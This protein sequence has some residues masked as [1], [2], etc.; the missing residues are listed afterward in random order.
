DV[1]RSARWHDLLHP[2]VDP[3]RSVKVARPWHYRRNLRRTYPLRSLV[4][5][6][7]LRP[8]RVLRRSAADGHWPEQSRA[9]GHQDPARTGK[10]PVRLVQ[11]LGTRDPDRVVDGLELGDLQEPIRLSNRCVRPTGPLAN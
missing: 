7:V 2:A 10:R 5:L 3:D 11:L 1:L 9:A 8:D 4:H 6:A